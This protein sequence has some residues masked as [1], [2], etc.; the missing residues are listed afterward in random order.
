MTISR[1]LLGH[2]FHYIGNII[3]CSE[4]LSFAQLSKQECK[5]GLLPP[6]CAPLVQEDGSTSLS[7]RNSGLLY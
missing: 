2:T 1:E 3:G 4:Q 6:T 7:L 5:I